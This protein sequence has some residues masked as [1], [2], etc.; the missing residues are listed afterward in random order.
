MLLKV[1]ACELIQ[2]LSSKVR[3]NWLRHQ[4]VASGITPDVLSFAGSAGKIA[5]KTMERS[6]LFKGWPVGLVTLI[7]RLETVTGP[8]LSGRDYR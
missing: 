8:G 5:T 7:C 2:G 4:L 3:G 1:G 6:E